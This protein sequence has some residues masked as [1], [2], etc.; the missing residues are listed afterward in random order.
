MSSPSPLPVSVVIPAYNRAELLRRALASVAAQEPRPAAEVIVVDDCSSDGTGDVAAESGAR[1]IRHARNRGE[2]AARNTG[3]EAASHEWVALLDSD[4]EWLPHHL[5]TLWPLR[6]GHVLVAGS[7]LRRGDDGSG[8]RFHGTPTRVPRLL[9]SPL[10]LVYPSNLIPAS[11]SMIKRDE[12]LAVG[13]YRE[14]MH[15]AA[16]FDLYLRVLE[17]GSGVVAPD[18]SAIYHVHDGQVSRDRAA[19]HLSARRVIESYADRPW[20]SARKLQRRLGVQAWDELR[21][22]AWDGQRRVAVDRACWIARH[23]QRTAGVVGIWGVRL[24]E[25]RRAAAIGGGAR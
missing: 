11:A 21:Q 10:D 3:V 13:G 7:A 5:A 14:G 9:R 2:G 22:A 19:M 15:Q 6:E 20:W 24:R 4:D 16:D 8:D 18:V 23:P 12:I 25:R 17:R 1:V